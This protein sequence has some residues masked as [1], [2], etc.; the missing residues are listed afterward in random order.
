MIILIIGNTGF[1]LN[2]LSFSYV[3]SDSSPRATLDKQL[4]IVAW[5]ANL[6]NLLT[7]V[8]ENG[9]CGCMLRLV[10]C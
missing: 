8:R 9:E 5:A 6:A 3:A 4:S 7:K 1:R 10:A 2:I